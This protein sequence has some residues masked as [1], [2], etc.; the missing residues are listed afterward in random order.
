[1]CKVAHGKKFEQQ[2]K[3]LLVFDV[4]RNENVFW[5]PHVSRLLVDG[6]MS[7]FFSAHKG[8]VKGNATVGVIF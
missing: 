7:A 5:P 6:G 8:N 1:M 4:N 2:R 3:R